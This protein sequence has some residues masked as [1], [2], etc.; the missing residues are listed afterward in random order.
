MRPF[1]ARSAVGLLV[2]AGLSAA[3]P[4]PSQAAS[5][6]YCD[7]GRPAPCLVSVLRDG[8][9]V[10]RTAYLATVDGYTGSDND[11]NTGF[12]LNKAGM[13]GLGP[14]EMGHVFTVTMDTGTIVP[15]IVQGWGTD[16]HATR[17]DDGDGTWQVTLRIEPADMLM[18]CTTDPG[19]GTPHCPATADPSDNIQYI[20]GHIDDAY[21]FGATDTERQRM[22]GME[23]YSNINLFWYP[24]AITVAGG[25]VTMDYAMMNSHSYAG[26]ATFYGH[27]NVR[28][29]NNV[30]RQLYGIPNPETMT[31]GSFTSTATSGAVT[32]A[33]EPGGDAWAITL[34]GMTFS[35][36][37]LRLTRGT[38]VPTRPTG[39]AA[40]RLAIHRGKVWGIST[41]RG[42]KVTGYVVT[43]E[44]GSEVLRAT[45]RTS[46]ITITGLR[47]GRAY[48]CQIKAL[49]KAGPSRNSVVVRLPA[50]P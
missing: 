37:H 50:R 14:A 29:T 30:L 11:H 42:A 6:Q 17:I 46:P 20:N 12:T 15:R 33:P 24:P 45:G 19:T 26:G 1:L 22:W 9:A 18:S 3:T 8:V 41:P 35:K 27:A 13:Y 28:L 38:I 32:S 2:V 10:D 16:G 21:W 34:D 49:S 5:P 36:Q 40:K 44:R 39:V 48:E 4:S 47:A 25:V 43:C 23:A 7:A 31:P